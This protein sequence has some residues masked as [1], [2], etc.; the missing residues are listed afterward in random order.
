MDDRR[1]WITAVRNRFRLYRVKKEAYWLDGQA[2]QGH[3]SPLMWQSLSS[4]LG[5]DRD[6]TGSTG[7]TADGLAAFFVGKVDD[8]M[9]DTAAQPLPTVVNTA[10]SSLSSLR[11]CS[12]AEVQRMMMTS[13]AK[14][15][16]QDRIPTFLCCEFVDLLL[17]YTT[18]MVNASLR[19][20][21]LPDSQKHAIILPIVKKLGL[22]TADMANFRPVY[23]LTFMSKVTERVVAQQ[24]SAEDLFPRCQL[25]YTT[26]NNT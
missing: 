4:L 9:D 24:L 15:C 20:G 26:G 14:S 19:Q 22:N 25:A 13:P 21:R 10:R 16:L 5:R 7:H 3:S 2:Q 8:I 17:P 1:S 18:S 6:V 23:N 12:E 11:S